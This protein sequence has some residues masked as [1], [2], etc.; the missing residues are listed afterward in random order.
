VIVVQGE[1]RDQFVGGLVRQ[2]HVSNQ[3]RPVA[4]ALVKAAQAA[5][6]AY[7][8][9]CTFGG[10]AAERGIS[11]ANARAAEQRVWIAAGHP[12]ARTGP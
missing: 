12:A 8:S 10:V 6:S 7:A 9:C 2:V 1:S 4:P 3:P 11:Y 5:W